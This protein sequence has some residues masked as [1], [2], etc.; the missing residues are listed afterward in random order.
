MTYTNNM[1]KH[2]TVTAKDQGKRLDKFLTEQFKENSRSSLQ[3]QIRKS[4]ITV[5]GKTVITGMKL[6][7]G[8]EI[9]ISL[10]TPKAI[11][12]KPDKNIFLDILFEDENYIIINKQSGIVVHPSQ[13][14]PSQTLVN[15]LM[16]YC[17][18]I[19]SVGDD[20]IR[21]GIV[22]RLDKDVSG[23]MVIAKNQNSFT[24][25]KNQFKERMVKKKYT[26]LVYGNMVP[27]SGE[28]NLPIGRSK[29]QSNRMS[30]KRIGE[31]RKAVTIYKTIKEY[32]NFSLLEM[33]TKTGRTH[34]IRVHLLSKGNPVVGDNTYYL[35]KMKKKAKINR[36]FLHANS[37]QFIDTKGD[38]MKFSANLP[39]DLDNYL[40]QLT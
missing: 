20:P 31:G 28:I 13:S 39:K 23:T 14:T 21:P 15:G 10:H 29:T 9:Q 27:P 32:N 7:V 40:K 16:A 2:I 35:K 30:V 12:I 4:E 6:K 18:N 17:P 5:D 11:S 8:N 1:D 37:L 22:H 34:Q 3:S 25:L 19:I 33:E 38:L 24:H 26:A 36:I